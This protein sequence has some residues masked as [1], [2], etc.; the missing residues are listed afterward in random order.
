MLAGLEF[1][2][3]ALYTNLR[4]CSKKSKLYLNMYYSAV[5]EYVTELLLNDRTDFNDFFC[6]LLEI[7]KSAGQIIRYFFLASQNGTDMK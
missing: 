5:R 1:R 2:L 6:M 7:Y 4:I 3:V